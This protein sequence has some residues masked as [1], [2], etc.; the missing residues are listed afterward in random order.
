MYLRQ[1]KV[2]YAITTEYFIR[3]ARIIRSK[4][5]ARFIFRAAVWQ[6]KHSVTTEKVC[7]LVTRNLF[8]CINQRFECILEKI[9]NKINY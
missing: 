7:L 1:S 3:T 9:D 5:F 8:V 6:S 4:V 2:P